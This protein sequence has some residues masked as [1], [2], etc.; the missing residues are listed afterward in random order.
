LMVINPYTGSL[1]IFLFG[2]T[3]P[4]VKLLNCHLMAAAKIQIEVR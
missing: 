1:M 3:M 4:V 2:A